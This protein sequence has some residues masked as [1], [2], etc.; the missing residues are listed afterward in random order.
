MSLQY[1][2]TINEITDEL[3]STCVFHDFKWLVF[4]TSVFGATVA[5]TGKRFSDVILLITA[6]GIIFVAIMVK[7]RDL[8]GF[9]LIVSKQFFISCGGSINIIHYLIA[10]YCSLAT[11]KFLRDYDRNHRN[12]S[13][14][15][16]NGGCLG[17]IGGQF[18]FDFVLPDTG[19]VR[20][21]CSQLNTL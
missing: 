14:V 21:H 9:V 4:F 12:I 20:K 2:L 7:F 16:F 3:T 8:R 11:G 15:L 10:G 6:M 5:F 1:E 18:L 13:S 17:A 19:A